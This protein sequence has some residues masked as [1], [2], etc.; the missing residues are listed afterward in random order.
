[1][2]VSSRK[3]KPSIDL[4][5]KKEIERLAKYGFDNDTRDFGDFMRKIESEFGY[6]NASNMLKG[7]YEGAFP[8][9]VLIKM[10][11]SETA[12]VFLKNNFK[13]D[14]PQNMNLEDK[15]KLAEERYDALMSEL[16]GGY[17][18]TEFKKEPET[19]EIIVQSYE[20]PK[21]NVRQSSY[22]KSDGV[23]VKGS[24]RSYVKWDSSSKLYI[25]TLKQKN[26]KL[27]EVVAE[28]NKSQFGLDNRHTDKA[29]SRQYYRL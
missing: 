2:Q 4:D 7:N 10:F 3:S 16:D 8:H 13:S 5:D 20:P 19:K 29:I 26:Y 11:Q 14:L 23:K 27:K 22:V 15:E 25:Q 9:D 21:M 6:G 28:Y 18:K 1:M 17:T 24:N 12:E